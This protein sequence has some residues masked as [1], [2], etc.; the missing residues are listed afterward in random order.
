[1]LCL[2]FFELFITQKRTRKVS[3]CLY[4]EGWKDSEYRQKLDPYGKLGRL[5]D[6]QEI[7]VKG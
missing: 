2:A 3:G 1:M 5:E 6:K 4:F 7:I